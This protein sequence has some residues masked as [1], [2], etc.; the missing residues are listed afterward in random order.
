MALAMNGPKTLKR[1]KK[2]KEEPKRDLT[3]FKP[4][5]RSAYAIECLAHDMLQWAQTDT[6]LVIETFPLSR[7][8]QPR[9]FMR[10]AEKNEFFADA[11]ETVKLLFFQRL[12]IGWR[13]KEFDAKNAEKF[14][15]FY[16]IDYREFIKSMAR[17]PDN[18]DQRGSITVQLAPIPNNP[19]VPVKEN[20]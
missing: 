16:N 11:L 6:T 9:M 15:A 20:R 10:L 7:N 19:S 4:P 1:K 14:C 5:P 2:P 3:W 12:T 18:Q 17:P 13:T 8:I